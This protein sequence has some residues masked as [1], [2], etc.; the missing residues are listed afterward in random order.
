[1]TD[2]VC[3]VA[4]HAPARQTTVDVVLPAGCPVGVLLPSIV[5]RCSGTRTRRQ[6]RCGGSWPA[7]AVPPSIHP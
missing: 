5:T 6:N 1:M 3:R 4:V 7:R 2:T